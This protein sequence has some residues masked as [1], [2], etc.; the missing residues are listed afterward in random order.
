MIDQKSS[1]MT[2]KHKCDNS[3]HGGGQTKR[4]SQSRSAPAAGTTFRNC[5]WSCPGSVRWLKSG[6]SSPSSRFC[7]QVRTA[8]QKGSPQIAHLLEK[9]EG[10]IIGRVS[11]C[12]SLETSTGVR[13]QHH[14]DVWEGSSMLRVVDNLRLCAIQGRSF[15]NS[16][17]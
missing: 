1:D 9:F 5:A 8:K 12:S 15:S 2:I 14:T 7:P 13:I 10:T 3:K 16:W 11:P 4:L 17:K 6:Q